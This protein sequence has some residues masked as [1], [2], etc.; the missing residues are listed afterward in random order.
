MERGERVTDGELSRENSGRTAERYPRQVTGY[1][2][3]GDEVALREERKKGDDVD[4]REERQTK[5]SSLGKASDPLFQGGE[6]RS[7]T[8]S[9]ALNLS[10]LCETPHTWVGFPPPCPHPFSPQFRAPD[11]AL[12][13]ECGFCYESLAIHIIGPE[14]ER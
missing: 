2:K 10:Q 9:F 13:P 12:V 6:E 14:R 3:S 5:N 4:L 1:G 8:S 7:L 11:K